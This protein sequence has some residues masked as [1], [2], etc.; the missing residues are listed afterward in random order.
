MINSQVDRGSKETR[1]PS[2]ASVIGNTGANAW[3]ILEHTLGEVKRVI[4]PR[5][6]LIS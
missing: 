3:P 5:T 1:D 2:A 4:L 6:R